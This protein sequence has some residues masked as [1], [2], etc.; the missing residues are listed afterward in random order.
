VSVEE[1]NK[2]LHNLDFMVK[3]NNHN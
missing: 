3:Y 1:N 2:I